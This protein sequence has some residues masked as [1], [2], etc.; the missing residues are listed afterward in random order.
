MIV[1]G[2]NGRLQ[3]KNVLLT[4]VFQNFDKGIVVAELE[5]LDLPDVLSEVIADVAHQLRVRV[6]SKNDGVSVRSQHQILKLRVPIQTKR[7][8][9]FKVVLRG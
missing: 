7:D 8:H 9:R 3:D 5:Y 6:T 4:N 1:H 2:L